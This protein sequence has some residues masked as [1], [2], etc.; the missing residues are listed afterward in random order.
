MGSRL[1]V[2]QSPRTL[3]RLYRQDITSRRSMTSMTSHEE[4]TA[5]EPREPGLHRVVLAKMFQVSVTM[6]L[7]VLRPLSEKLK[8]RDLIH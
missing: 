8:A 3:P 7:L 1:R 5:T 2:L 6:R 4:R